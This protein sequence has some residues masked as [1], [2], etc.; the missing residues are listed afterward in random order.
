MILYSRMCNVCN[1]CNARFTAVNF[2]RKVSIFFRKSSDKP[3]YLFQDKKIFT[4]SACVLH[5]CAISV[6]PVYPWRRVRGCGEIVAECGK[7]LVI[8]AKY[9]CN[10]V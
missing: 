3:V 6:H 7:N 4:N 1:D 8:S 2:L 10:F 5:T 9:P